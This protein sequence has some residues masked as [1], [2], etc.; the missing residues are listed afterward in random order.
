MT[1]YPIDRTHTS[2]NKESRA[3]HRIRMLLL[4]ATVGSGPS[5][6]AWLCDPQPD[7]PDARV[8][9]HYLIYKTGKIYQLVDDDEA[10]WH[11]GK[12]FWLGLTSTEIKLCSLG[13]E[14]ENLNT[15]RDPYPTVQL[16]AAH[17]LCQRLVQQYEIERAYCVRHLDVATPKGRKTD[18]AGFPWAQFVDGLYGVPPV[19]PPPRPAAPLSYRVRAGVTAG[20]RVRSAP[21]QSAAVLLRL[22]AGDVWAGTRETGELVALE[23]FPTGDTWIKDSQGRY[24]W[25]GLLELAL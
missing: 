15:G 19:T 3:G 11:A 5:S 6:L 21:R 7:D 20:A 24:V 14:L 16:D 9:I 2:P 1:T 4:H 25:A 12:S 13:I 18:P 23:G 17:W 10:A 8:S 22:W